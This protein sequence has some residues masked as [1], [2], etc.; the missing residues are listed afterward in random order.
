MNQLTARA[1]QRRQSFRKCAKGFDALI[2]FKAALND[3]RK[4]P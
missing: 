4:T 3:E 1:Y 2:K